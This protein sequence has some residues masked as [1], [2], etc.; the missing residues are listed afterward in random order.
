M[1][2][3]H[4]AQGYMTN[5]MITGVVRP[6]CHGE[7]LNKHPNLVSVHIITSGGSLPILSPFNY[8]EQ[9]NKLQ[10]SLLSSLSS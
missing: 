4:C 2:E 1:T 6:F 9:T 10:K 5:L 3:L 8:Q 7:S